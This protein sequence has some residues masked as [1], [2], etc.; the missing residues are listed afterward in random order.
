M[1]GWAKR[2]LLTLRSV[3]EFV[4][5]HKIES[6]MSVLVLLIILYFW[7]TVGMLLT[8]AVFIIV[9][10]LSMIYQRFL[11]ISLG[12]ELIMLGM[13][14]IGFLHGPLAAFIVGSVAFFIS[15]LLNEHLM[16]ASIVSFLGIGVVSALL[17]AFEGLGITTAGII[18]TVIY[19][20]IIGPGYLMLGSNPG[21]VGLFVS[22]HLLFN[23]WAFTVLAPRIINLLG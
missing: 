14:V 5:K 15:M 2:P 1:R 16:H 11:R 13:V 6:L 23:L 17:P 21:K 12:I 7:S 3:Q 8:M 19:D 20:A 22:T 4:A 10:A 18:L 9:G